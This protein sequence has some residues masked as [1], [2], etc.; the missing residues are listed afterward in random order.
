[1]KGEKGKLGLKVSKGCK[2]MRIFL[3]EVHYEMTQ[4]YEV[5]TGRC[6]LFPGG[7]SF[8]ES[9]GAYYESG[10]HGYRLMV[11]RDMKG[12]MGFTSFRSPWKDDEFFQSLKEVVGSESYKGFAALVRRMNRY[13]K[14]AV[15][16]FKDP[17]KVKEKVDLVDVLSAIGDI[18]RE[19]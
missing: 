1:M 14:E 2:Q 6:N 17:S 3:D 13:R 12:N 19:R 11:T 9:I 18:S 5:N 15:K 16:A 10:E 4:K 7:M 8:E